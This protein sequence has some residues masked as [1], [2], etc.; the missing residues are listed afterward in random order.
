MTRPKCGGIASSRPNL[1]GPAG[2]VSMED[3]LATELVQLGA[4]G[5]SDT[6]GGRYGP[7]LVRRGQSQSMITENRVRH[8][9]R[10]YEELMGL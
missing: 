10:G 5:S 4:A 8:F 9:W 2:L 1:V 7:R 6:V 3:T